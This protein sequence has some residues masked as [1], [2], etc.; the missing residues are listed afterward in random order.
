MPLTDY[1]T[2]NCC[3]YAQDLQEKFMEDA[4]LG[5][6]EEERENFIDCHADLHQVLPHN[7]PEFNVKHRESVACRSWICG[8]CGE[9]GIFHGHEGCWK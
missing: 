7:M 9:A 2:C 5:L 3:L 4:R 8:I 1:F 6:P